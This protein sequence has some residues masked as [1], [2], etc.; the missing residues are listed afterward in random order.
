MEDADFQLS[1][2][3]QTNPLQCSIRHIETVSAHRHEYAEVAMVLERGC[4][5]TLEDRVYSLAPD[6]IVYIEPQM[7]H[8]FRSSGAL[9]AVVQFEEASFERAVPRPYR[10]RFFC[11]S[12]VRQNE[13][14]Y[15]ALRRLVARTVKNN[16]ELHP[17]YELRNWSLM[18]EFGD[19]LFNNFR[20]DAPEP[21]RRSQKR[22][23]LVERISHVI[24]ERYAEQIS[25]TEL[26]DQVGLSAP[27]LSKFFSKNFGMSYLA[28]LSGIR[29]IHAERD[30]IETDD[31]IEEISAKNGFPNSSSFVRAFRA[32]HGML[33]SIYRKRHRERRVPAGPAPIAQSAHAASL[34]K[35]LSPGTQHDPKLDAGTLAVRLEANLDVT[36][37]GRSLTHAWRELLTVS[38]AESLLHE[39][40]RNE[41]RS[42][43]RGIGF[44]RIAFKGIFDD[45]LRVCLRDQ[46]GELRFSWGGVDRVLDFAL[47]QGLEPLICLSFMPVELALLPNKRLFG[48]VVSPPKSHAEWARLVREF[49]EHCI[50]RYG[51]GRMATW[52]FNVWHEADLAYYGFS[53]E[54]DFYDFYKLTYDTLRQT[55]P[56]ARIGTPSIFYLDEVAHNEWVERFLNWT[57]RNG[58]L[59]DFVAFTYYDVELSPDAASK[60][61]FGFVGHISLRR[62][63]DGL[64]SFCDK[65]PALAQ[66]LPVCLMEWNSSPSQQ[67]LLND[68]CYKS[69]Y[70][71]KSL[72]ENYDRIGSF[73]Y[74][75]L[76][77]LIGEGVEPDKLFFGGIGLATKNGIPKA[78][79]RALELMSRLGDVAI[80]SGP[81]WFATCAGEDR[82]DV[83][84]ILY[85]YQHFSQLYAR[86]E[87]LD[88]T[89]LDR[90]TP[91]AMDRKLETKLAIGGL[92]GGAYRVR[93]T[94]VCR[95]S[96]SAFDSWVE[97]GGIE[98]ADGNDLALL[99]AASVPRSRTTRVD[100]DE[101]T[102]NLTASL[103]ALEVRLVEIRR[104]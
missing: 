43:Q 80:G 102:L 44:R 57:R 52:Q 10:P 93:E 20:I 92:A 51:K 86:G 32:E 8:S 96:G 66:G 30:L 64:A 14:A 59:P 53:D 49:L 25:L 83:R 55:L 19:V 13:A 18:F 42:A 85:N 35:Y 54:R 29:L 38:D 89:E 17:G 46:Q 40:I 68:T 61:T 81:G 16:S 56:E 101:G 47:E 87:R 21:G 76:S 31:T 1:T 24:K 7:R 11:N 104:A 58:C 2:L 33:P 73:G 27:Y 41:V 5:I 100:A 3:G 88:M 79:M 70:L 48:H 39:E 77:D 94:R 67:D 23:E 75:S 28:Y 65:A 103:D 34:A 60:E 97:A 15:D 82:S 36:H 84:V 69:C 99:R 91:F 78:S 6:D 71:V 63:G 98:P 95:G 26:A 37:K 22:Y 50:S 45:G 9:L 4:T 74:W 62:D 12:S 72:V 90:Y